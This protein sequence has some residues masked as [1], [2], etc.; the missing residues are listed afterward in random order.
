M[1]GV[2]PPGVGREL[3]GSWRELAPSFPSPK[4]E[5]SW[6]GVG[7][8]VIREMNVPRLSYRVLPQKNLGGIGP[9]PKR[10]LPDLPKGSPA[11]GLA[12]T[13][14]PYLITYNRSKFLSFLLLLT[15][16]VRSWVPIWLE[17]FA[18]IEL[19]S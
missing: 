19:V 2:T 3:T 10:P 6:K 15:Y 7:I 4:S 13:I 16:F 17:T 5:G 12:T 1:G 14:Y 11:C 8:I 18:F 9:P